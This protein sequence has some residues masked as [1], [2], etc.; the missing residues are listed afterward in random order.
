MLAII[1]REKKLASTVGLILIVLLL[2]FLPAICLPS[3]LLISG[4]AESDANLAAW[5]PFLG[6]IISLNGLL[7]PLVNYGR[8]KDIRK[9]VRALIVCSKRAGRVVQHPPIAR[10]TSKSQS[11]RNATVIELVEESVQRSTDN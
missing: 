7:N 5:R 11:S 1:K 8:N 3:I 10:E 2:T 9:A 4:F 6:F